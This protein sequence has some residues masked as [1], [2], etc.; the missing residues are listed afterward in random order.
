VCF[1][2][3]PDLG[4]G[5]LAVAAECMNVC[6]CSY[7]DG[8]CF[9]NHVWLVNS[10]LILMVQS[11]STLRHSVDF[12]YVTSLLNTL[13]QSTFNS[14][15]SLVFTLIFYWPQHKLFFQLYK[16]NLVFTIVSKGA[17]S[18]SFSLVCFVYFIFFNSYPLCFITT[19]SIISLAL[20]SFSGTTL[21]K[22]QRCREMSNVISNVSSHTLS[23]I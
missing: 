10:Y 4:T 22:G 5:S 3:D 1:I 18:V 9:Q 7:E 20:L 23:H 15:Y 16:Q 6:L 2:C 12:N 11:H 14:V 8:Y 21:H 17:H 19:V 13:K